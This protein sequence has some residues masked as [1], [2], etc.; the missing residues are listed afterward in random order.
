MSKTLRKSFL[1]TT[2]AAAL[3]TGL[4]IASAQTGGGGMKGGAGD[5]GMSQGQAGGA[6]NGT[7]D[8]PVAVAPVTPKRSPVA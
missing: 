1:V 8:R 3:V 4:T 7:K 6:P 2:A 5:H